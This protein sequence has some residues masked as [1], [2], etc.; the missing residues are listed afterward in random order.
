M[1]NKTKGVIVVLGASMMWAIEPILV[2]L[3]YAYTDVLSTFTTRTI[4][5]LITIAAYLLLTGRNFRVRTKYLPKLV[6]VSIAATLFADLM[7]VYALGKVQVINAVMIGHMQ[8]IFIVLIGFAFLKDDRIT[9]F[10]YLGILF[11]IIAGIL[12]TS[13]TLSNLAAVRIGTVGDLYVLFATISWATTA[14]VAR[15]YLKELNAALIAFYRFLFGGIAFV[16]YATFLKGITINNAYQM[17]LGV[18]IGIGTILYYEGIK[19]IKAAQVSAL[20]L[21]T[22]FFATILG[23]FILKETITMIQFIGIMSL[24]GGIYFLSRKEYPANSPLN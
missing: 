13:R 11:M 14:I 15:R 17:V 6:Y 12:V 5:C 23:F 3:S 19:L 8:P 16:I 1:S 18:I 20:E 22:P 24:F 9:R 10:D 21:S 2:K 4:F 7:Y